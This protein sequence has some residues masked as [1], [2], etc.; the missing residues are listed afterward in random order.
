MDG[1][2]DP[3]CCTILEVLKKIAKIKCAQIKNTTAYT[4][5]LCKYRI[6]HGL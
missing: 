1:G 6:S 3:H 5:K 4:L 2:D